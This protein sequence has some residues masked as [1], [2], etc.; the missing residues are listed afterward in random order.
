MLK[1]GQ[2]E[3]RNAS[4]GYAFH[5]IDLDHFKPVNDTHGHAAG[6]EVLQV[7]ARRLQGLVRRDD[8]VVR[9]GGDEFAI[10]QSGVSSAAGAETLAAR[11]IDLASQPIAIGPVEVR[12]G[13]SIG[14]AVCVGGSTPLLHAL[15]LADRAL[16]RAK[17]AGGGCCMLSHVDEAAPDVQAA[18]GDLA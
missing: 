10:V 17:R 9:L 2:V 13:A 18:A 5:Y 4:D 7:I 3:R 8:I 14:I 11:V 16:Y 6:D 12:V 15:Q 1:D